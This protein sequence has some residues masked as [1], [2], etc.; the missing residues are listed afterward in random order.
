MSQGYLTNYIS[1]GFM[2]LSSDVH[3]VRCLNILMDLNGTNRDLFAFWA[4]IHCGD[5]RKMFLT[6]AFINTC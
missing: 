3:Y 5:L 2:N 1:M 6:S 4:S